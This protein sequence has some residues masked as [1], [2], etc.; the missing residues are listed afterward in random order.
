MNCTIF[1]RVSD[2]IVGKGASVRVLLMN[3]ANI[4]VAEGIKEIVVDKSKPNEWQKITFQVQHDNDEAIKARVALQMSASVGKVW[5]DDV[6]ISVTQ[7]AQSSFNDD[8]K[9]KKKFFENIN[10]FSFSYFY[11]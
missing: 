7:H 5:Y 8:G 3:G 11:I 4:Y 10:C 1:A 6:V 9:Q 2:N